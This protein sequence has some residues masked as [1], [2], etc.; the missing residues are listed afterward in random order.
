LSFHDALTSGFN[1][2][3]AK[4]IDMNKM[5]DKV[6]NATG[7]MSVQKHLADDKEDFPSAGGVISKSAFNQLFLSC[8]DR[9]DRYGE[10]AH[11]IFI[12]ID[13]YLQ[14]ISEASPYDAKIVSAKLAHHLVT[15]RRQSDIISQ[16]KENEYALLLLRP[17]SESEPLEAAHR[18]AESLSKCTDIAFDQK[19]SINIR[20]FLMRLPTGETSVEHRMAI[21]QQQT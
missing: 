4:P 11:I 18:F 3:V 16:T 10:V 15:L 20:V 7:I 5:L 19:L 8:M 2:F 6:D 17:M 21:Y 14:I 1:D 9:A 13:N 12:T